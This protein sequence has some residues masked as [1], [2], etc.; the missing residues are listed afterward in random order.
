M[1]TKNIKKIIMIESTLYGVI[2]S[3]L[4]AIVATL[5]YNRH[6][7]ELN[8]ISLDGG[9]TKTVAHNIPFKYIFNNYL[10]EEIMSI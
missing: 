3:I 5:L 10:K 1:S 2:R 4:S 7:S 6:I 9:F 8:N